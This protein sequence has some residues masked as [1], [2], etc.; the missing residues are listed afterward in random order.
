MSYQNNVRIWKLYK[1]L[2]SHIRNE[3]NLFITPE[4]IFGVQ[5]HQI[6]I[7]TEQYFDKTIQQMMET[8]ISAIIDSYE[9]ENDYEKY[10]SLTTN[11]E[12]VVEQIKIYLQ[13]R[14]QVLQDYP[15]FQI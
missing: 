5:T 8:P 7:D 12:K 14:P 2:P 13:L 10:W 4:N 6:T 15:E 1:G 11:F 9:N 3:I